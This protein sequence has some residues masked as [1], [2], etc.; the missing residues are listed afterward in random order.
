MLRKFPSGKDCL[1]IKAMNGLGNWFRTRSRR[2]SGLLLV[3]GATLLASPASA[4]DSTAADLETIT[5]LSGEP[6]A[7]PEFELTDHNGR[8]VDKRRLQGR[9]NLMFFGYTHCPDIC[10]TTLADLSQVYASIED[11][12]IREALGVY[13]VSVDPARDDRETLAEYIG[14]FE[15]AFNAASGSP[16]ALESL[17]RAL[18]VKFTIAQAAPE[19]D[20]YNVSHSGFVVLVDPGVRHAGLWFSSPDKTEAAARD[21]IRLIESGAAVE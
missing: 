4:I 16:Q 2:I 17:T 7:L 19:N 14:Y 6:R 11:P 1:A 12:A 21:L 8:S 18:G 15:S 3:L 5:L 9:W 13:F 10:P 20:N